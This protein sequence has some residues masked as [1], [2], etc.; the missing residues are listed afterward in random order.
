MKTLTDKSV[1][2]FVC[3]LPYGQIGASWDILIDLNAFWEQVERLAKNETTPILMFCTTRFGY[4]LIK[5]KEEWFRHDLVWEKTNAVGFLGVNRA[6]LRA[7]ELV[8][9]FSKK[10]PFYK[11]VDIVGDFPAGG[12]GRSKSNYIPS[13]ATLPNT[14]ITTAAGRRC[15]RSVIKFANKK[16]KGGHP[17]AKPIELY[18]WL[19]ERYCPDGGT[20]LDPTAGSFN[21]VRAALELKRK[22]IGIE[23][24][25]V[26]F[27]TANAALSP[28][29]VSATPTTE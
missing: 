25:A 12:G 17:T 10:A 5:S 9:V 6:P 29:A 22:A 28:P 20:I 4:S 26:Y 18:K 7:H 3:D 21:A 16:T 2:C 19:I 23:K 11:R 13:V 8:Y 15:V 24:D 14:S 27:A 1:D